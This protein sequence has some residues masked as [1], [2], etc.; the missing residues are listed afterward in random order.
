MTGDTRKSD[1]GNEVA[2][3][4]YTAVL[5]RFEKSDPESG[6]E[7]LAV[8]LL[9]SSEEVVAERIVPKW[10]LPEDARRQDAVLE[11]AVRNGFVT[12]V[13]YD[14]EATER[15]SASAQ[16]RFDALAKRPEDSNDNN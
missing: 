2:D 14:S 6:G 7:K 10:R 4:R 16:S 13:E 15:R 8:L 11:L 3:G 1:D 9:E 12:S 5:D